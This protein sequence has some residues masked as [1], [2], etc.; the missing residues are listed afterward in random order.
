MRCWPAFGIS[1]TP[2]SAGESDVWWQGQ[3][4]Q[5]HRPIRPPIAC[6]FALLAGF[7]PRLGA[8]TRRPRGSQQQ[9]FRH[10]Q[11]LGQGPSAVACCPTCSPSCFFGALVTAG[12][13]APGFF[14][15]RF[16]LGARFGRFVRITL[17]PPLCLLSG[18][19]A[20]LPLN[21]L[22]VC[23]LYYPPP[24]P[25]R[26]RLPN[27]P[28]GHFGGPGTVATNDTAQYTLPRKRPYSPWGYLPVI[29]MR[30]SPPRGK[31]PRPYHTGNSTVTPREGIA[32]TVMESLGRGIACSPGT[33]SVLHS[34]YEKFVPGTNVITMRLCR[35]CGTFLPC[36]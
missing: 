22:P 32:V 28:R 25:P 36:R 1:L 8:C 15:P 26:A 12:V 2:G 18:P 19:R 21:E 16:G 23:E 27:R 3:S 35:I 31:V 20:F 17:V 6:G 13:F 33:D 11:L 29:P 30:M 9:G 34:G 10:P 24:R 7:R 14:V 4:G 5:I